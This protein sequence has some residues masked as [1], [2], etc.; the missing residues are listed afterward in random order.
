M[1]V[2]LQPWPLAFFEPCALARSLPG[3]KRFKKCLYALHIVLACL[4]G[5]SKTFLSLW[6]SELGFAREYENTEKS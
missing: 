6:V 2:A 4:S 1:I 3:A 5:K